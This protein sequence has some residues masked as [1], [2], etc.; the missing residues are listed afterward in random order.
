MPLTLPTRQ[1]GSRGGGGASFLLWGVNQ[2]RQVEAVGGLGLGVR[3]LPWG[4]RRP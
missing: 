4:R 2:G 3:L 1:R